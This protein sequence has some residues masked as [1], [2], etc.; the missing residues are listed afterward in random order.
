MPMKG[1]LSA[2]AA[3]RRCA[4]A[5][6]RAFPRARIDLLPFADGGEGTAAALAVGEG[7]RWRR[8]AVTGPAGRRVAVRWLSDRSR[9]GAVID[10]AEACGLSLVPAGRRDPMRATSRGLGEW[11]LHAARSGARVIR[12]GLG[13]TATVDGG[14]GTLS[15]LGVRF[16]DARGNQVGDGGEAL[17]RIRRIDASVARRRLRGI[18]ILLL[19]DVRS[20]LLGPSGAARMFGPQKGAAPR[21]VKRLEA[22]L[23]NMSR[24]IARDCGRRVARLPGAGAA[25][26]IAAGF[27]GILGARI[28]PGA[29]FVARAVGLSRAIRRA[30]VVVTG[31]GRLDAQTLQGK[32][33]AEICRE[34]RRARKPV[35][36]VVGESRLSA[37]AARRLG[38]AA[39][40]AGRSAPA[41]AAAWI[42]ARA[43]RR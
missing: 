9:K 35:V 22:G 31:E 43:G 36:A 1:R 27:S 38:L 23:L 41:R 10:A 13:G 21:D 42:R 18:R 4:A 16:L 2:V 34:A 6:R 24:V 25:G 19:C 33:V 37:G 11:T 14:L 15:A 5:L 20:P 39:V 3:A 30:D 17:A 28:V 7:G 29:P 12:I 40:F 8:L 26:G 32:G